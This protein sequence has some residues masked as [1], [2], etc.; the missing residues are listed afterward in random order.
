MWDT[1]APRVSP[2]NELCRR[3]A[4]FV[5]V[6][7]VRPWLFLATLALASGCGPDGAT[8]G[9][10]KPGRDF[11]IADVIYDENYY[12]CTVE[13]M[14]FATKCGPGDTGQGD[15]NGACHY[16]VTSYRLSNY[17]LGQPGVKLVG[18]TCGGSNVPST[19]VPPQAKAN[20]SASQAKMQLDPN[21]APLLNR[22]IKKTAHPRQIFASAS[23]EADIIRDWATKYT[24]Q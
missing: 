4:A 20:Y 15:G 23:P 5:S 16:N 7:H 3:V 11:S 1:R 14:L 22:P 10:V 21:L 17:D 24:T 6:Q 12:Y 18:D 2:A 13:P 8:P 19:L 9:T